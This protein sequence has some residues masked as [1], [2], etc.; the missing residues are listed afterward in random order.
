MNKFLLCLLFL[1]LSA[2]SAFTLEDPTPR[3]LA[4]AHLETDK[5]IQTAVVRGIVA[6][7]SVFAARLHV[8][9]VRGFVTLRGSVKDRSAKITAG[10]IAR[11]VPGVRGVRNRLEIR[12][13]DR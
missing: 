2:G 4:P 6:N 8:R 5:E 1:A 10:K 13:L 12:R 11:A 3:P 9:V 7:P